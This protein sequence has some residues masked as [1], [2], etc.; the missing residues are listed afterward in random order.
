[1]ELPGGRTDRVG[2]VMKMD[3]IVQ[4]YGVGVLLCGMALGLIVGVVAVCEREFSPWGIWVVFLMFLWGATGILYFGWKVGAIQ[5]KMDR[6]TQHW[7][8]F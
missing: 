8:K 2:D 1:M 5:K 7:G 6:D 3:T 4:G